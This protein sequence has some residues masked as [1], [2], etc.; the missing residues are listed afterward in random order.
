MGKYI[1]RETA[2]PA[3]AV[4]MNRITISFAR[5]FSPE[6]V[7]D[8][9][10]TDHNT[11]WAASAMNKKTN[12]PIIDPPQKQQ[13][14]KGSRHDQVCDETQEKYGSNPVNSFTSIRA[15]RTRAQ[16]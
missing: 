13:P 10:F 14:P 15:G 11:Y 2:A 9:L 3:D 12:K 8:V 5:R 1:G 6:S 16:N 7:C 4:S